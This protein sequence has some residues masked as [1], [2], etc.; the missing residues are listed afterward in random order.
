MG[1][2]SATDRMKT[3][4]KRTPGAWRNHLD[5]IFSLKVRE[6]GKCE[7]C[8]SRRTLQCAHVYSRS[9]KELRWCLGN[10]LCLCSSCHFWAHQHPLDFAEWFKEYVGEVAYE[11]LRKASRRTRQWFDGEYD[12]VESD[13]IK[14]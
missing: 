4:K 14:A 8:G 9:N 3:A 5:K 11:A 6:R 1:T 2:S 7:R 10:A 13:I 12:K